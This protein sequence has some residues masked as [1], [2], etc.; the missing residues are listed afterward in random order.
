[1]RV[2]PLNIFKEKSKT[3]C[4]NQ[5]AKGFWVEENILIFTKYSYSIP[6]NNKKFT[7]QIRQLILF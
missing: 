7:T 3:L 6:T 4:L 2:F 5:L 1:M